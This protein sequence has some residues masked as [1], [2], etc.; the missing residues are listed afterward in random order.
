M[1]IRDSYI[2]NAK[3]K[4]I[5][6]YTFTNNINTLNQLSLV[7]SVIPFYLKRLN[8]HKKTLEHVRDVLKPLHRKKKLKFVMVSGIISE[9]HSE[10]IQIINF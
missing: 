3:P 1:C 5:P 8:N 9:K 6:I 2:S 4:D 10:A 7:G